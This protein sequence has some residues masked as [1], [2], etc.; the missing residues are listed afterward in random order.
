MYSH[1]FILHYWL[2]SRYSL[3]NSLWKVID[4][5]KPQLS[6][7]LIPLKTLC[8]RLLSFLTTLKK[9]KLGDIKSFLPKVIELMNKRSGFFLLSFPTLQ[10]PFSQYIRDDSTQICHFPEWKLIMLHYS[11]FRHKDRKMC[12]RESV[13]GFKQNQLNFTR[14]HDDKNFGKQE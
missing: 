10:Q 14:I 11:A 12:E 5:T 1:L 8:L 7:Y 9:L 13:G 6:P 2:P 3:F 4:K